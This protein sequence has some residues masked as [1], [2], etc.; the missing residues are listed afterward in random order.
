MEIPQSDIFVKKAI[1]TLK[2]L[3]ITTAPLRAPPKETGAPPSV[4]FVKNN[5]P[6]RISLVFLGLP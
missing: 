3:S 2:I 1:V 5:L 4:F 6:L